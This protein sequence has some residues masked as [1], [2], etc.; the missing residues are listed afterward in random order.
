LTLLGGSPRMVQPA[1]RRLPMVSAT[2]PG[3]RERK[4]T[5]MPLVSCPA[6]GKQVSD[7]APACPHCGH[8]AGRAGGGSGGRRGLPVWGKILLFL[9]LGLSVVGFAVVTKPS[10]AALRQAIRDKGKE[11]N[12]RGVR[13][14][15]DLIDDPQYAER[16][17]YHNHF[18][19]S[20]IQFTTDNGKVISV[21]SGSLG[22]ASVLDRW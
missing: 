12:A 6:C 9:L 1:P 17:T 22:S 13:S 11:L 2:D 19:S 21:A 8:T 18:L 15:L 20:E 4:G 7:A 5:T 14:P 16:F 10:E 3:R